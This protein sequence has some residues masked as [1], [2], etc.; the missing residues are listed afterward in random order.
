MSSEEK[1]DMLQ[2]KIN[3]VVGLTTQLIQ[4]IQ[5]DINR[6]ELQIE[7]MHFHDKQSNMAMYGYVMENY[8]DQIKKKKMDKRN[9]EMIME[10]L[11]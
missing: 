2:K 6:L 3:H 8:H 10:L 5:N 9:F 7:E 1:L 11:Q 4:N